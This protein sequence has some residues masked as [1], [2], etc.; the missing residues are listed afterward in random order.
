MN[1]NVPHLIH[2]RKYRHTQI[3][4]VVKQKPQIRVN[5][6]GCRPLHTILPY[7]L[8]V[9]GNQQKDSGLLIT[10]R[11]TGATIDRLEHGCHI[12]ETEGFNSL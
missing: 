2:H 10:V 3:I 6:K 7:W 8:V 1:P 9:Q 11:N 4:S 12:E 5:I